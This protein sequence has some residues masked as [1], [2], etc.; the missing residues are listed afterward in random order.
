MLILNFRITV[1]MFSAGE[2]SAPGAEWP[3]PV[4]AP[5][6]HFIRKR[7]TLIIT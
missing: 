7:D 1:P 3:N 5:A 6:R 2:P 4:K